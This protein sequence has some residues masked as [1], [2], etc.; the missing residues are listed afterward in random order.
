MTNTDLIWSKI[1]RDTRHQTADEADLDAQ[2]PPCFGEFIAWGTRHLGATDA[3][4]EIHRVGAPVKNALY[5]TCGAPIPASTQWLALCPAMLERLE[6]CRFC[7]TEHQRAGY[8]H[9]A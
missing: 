6:H 2:S 7:E 4:S 3:L 9:A 5:T 8:N 1:L